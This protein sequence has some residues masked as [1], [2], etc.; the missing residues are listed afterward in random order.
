MELD[1]PKSKAVEL[2]EK[3]LRTTLRHVQEQ[4][5][6]YVELREKGKKNRLIFFCILCLAPCHG[7]SCLVNHLKGRRHTERLA[8]AR[9]TLLK[10]NPWP[11]ND[12]MIFFHDHTKEQSKN[13]PAS[14]RGKNKSV[15]VADSRAKRK[16]SSNVG[17]VASTQT[18]LKIKGNANR[19]KKSSSSTLDGDK[20]G[21]ILVIPDVMQ[22]GK[23]SDLV[24]RHIGVGRIGARFREKKVGGIS[25]ILRIWCEWLGNTTENF[26]RFPNHHF[27]IVTFSYDYHLGRVGLVDGYDYMLPSVPYIQPE[28]IRSRRGKKRKLVSDPKNISEALRIQDH[29]SGKESQSSKS[30]KSNVLFTR[31]EDR[32]ARIMASKTLRKRLR[33]EYRYYAERFCEICRTKMLPGKD[34]AALLNRITGVLVCSSRNRHGI[35]HVYHISCIIQW[36]L[37]FEVEFAFDNQNEIKMA[38][39]KKGKTITP[40]CS[41]FCPECQSTGTI[42]KGDELEDTHAPITETTEYKKKLF[43]AREAWIKSPEMLDNCSIGFRFPQNYAPTYQEIVEQLKVLHF[44]RAIE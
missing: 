36:I 35:F 12:G 7:D 3:S 21:G 40:I 4:G 38:K 9:L 32:L 5:H 43:A 16:Y 25:A 24:V 34:V 8:S 28:N 10:P 17:P 30:S 13:V 26:D 14:D 37:H 1:L 27:A 22:E 23:A 6:P 44:Y 29:S 19:D 2:E 18:S 33:K 39:A 11:F 31:D 15:D 42:M 41:A 20:T